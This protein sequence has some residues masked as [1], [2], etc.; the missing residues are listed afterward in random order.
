[1]K[2]LSKRARLGL[3]LL[4]AAALGAVTAPGASA[5]TTTYRCAEQFPGAGF[6]DAHCLNSVGS[7]GGYR[8]ETTAPN[9]SYIIKVSNEQ[10]ASGTTAAAP[11][12]LETTIMSIPFRVKC[13]GAS[14]S[15]FLDNSILSGE[16]V[17]K[18]EA[19]LKFTSCAME[20]PDTQCQIPGGEVETNT[21]FGTSQGQ[22]AAIKISPLSGSTLATITLQNCLNPSL[23]G[24][25]PVTGS[26]KVSPTG[27]TGTTT[28]AVITSQATL[29]I[30]TFKAG[31]SASFVVK[32]QVPVTP[33]VVT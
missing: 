10:T 27:A 5:E 31:L 20:S 16:M 24:S 1:M 17:T 2:Q 11:A 26:L 23:N 9:T 14:G 18:G 29:K 33:L 21:L 30:L 7:G 19:V 15:G 4:A 32:G 25:Y 6:S 13:L 3:V 8:H 28:H 22:G 12:V